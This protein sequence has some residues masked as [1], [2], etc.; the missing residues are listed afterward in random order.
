MHA[1]SGVRFEGGGG[2][3]PK[4]IQVKKPKGREK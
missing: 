4:Y 1:K 2:T 3:L